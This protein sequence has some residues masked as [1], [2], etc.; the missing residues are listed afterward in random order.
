[1]HLG[2]HSARFPRDKEVPRSPTTMQGQMNQIGASRSIGLFTVSLTP[3]ATAAASSVE[4][5]FT[6]TGGSNSSTL[7]S[8]VALDSQDFVSV[9]GPASGNNVSLGNARINATG[10]LVITFINPSAGSLTH[11]AGTF[12]VL[13]ARPTKLQ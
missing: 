10:Q 7:N 4:Q 5:A 9:T 1:M 2:L 6:V 12:V 8:G 3:A 13:V 11:A